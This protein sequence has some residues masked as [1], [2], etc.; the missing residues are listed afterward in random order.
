MVDGAAGRAGGEFVGLTPI[1][2]PELAEVDDAEAADASGGG[3]SGRGGR[4]E[5]P[6]AILGQIKVK[7]K[8]LEKV[9]E[10][11]RSS[12]IATKQKASIWE[13]RI[14][15]SRKLVQGRNRLR[16]T[17]GHFASGAYTAPRAD[18]Y[19]L[20]LT[21]LTV[22]AVQQSKWLPLAARQCLPH[23]QRFH[24]VWSVQ[25]GSHP[26]FV[27]EPV[28]PNEQFVALGMIATQTEE[29]PP[30]RFVH[31]VPRSWVEPGPELNKLIWSDAGS[32][33]KPGSLW[34]CGTLQ[35]L[36]AAQGNASPAG[37]S[38]ALVRTRFTLG[39]HVGGVAGAPGEEAPEIEAGRERDS[40]V[41]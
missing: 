6:S 21:D 25:T 1:P 33:G 7:L 29:P 14:G 28:P 15:A 18:R 13:D 27:W 23:P 41:N 11:W 8:K 26:L 4:V 16:V 12:G 24:R 17:L 38:W 22:N 2:V 9:D 37:K 32:S 31:C 19:T 40:E 39:D 36:V 35:T 5:V 34:S 20:E 10:V 30:A 3:A